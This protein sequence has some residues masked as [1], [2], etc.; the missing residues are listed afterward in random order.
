VLPDLEERKHRRT[1]PSSTRCPLG[2]RQIIQEKQLVKD[3]LSNSLI[4][5]DEQDLRGFLG[6]LY[7][8]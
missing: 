3:Y 7:T 1:R 2:Q 4:G 8:L 5:Q 6:D